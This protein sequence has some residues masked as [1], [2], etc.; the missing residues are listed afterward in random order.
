MG[1]EFLQSSSG[2]TNSPSDN[3][4]FL[5]EPEE[6]SRLGVLALRSHP[7]LVIWC[8]GNE[9]AW[10]GRIP[11]DERHLN[12]KMLKGIVRELDP[13]RPFFP[14]SPSGPR[15]NF[16]LADV[17]KGVHHDIH[18]PWSYLGDGAHYEEFN[19]DDSLF[20]SETGAPSASRWEA[21]HRYAGGYAVWPPKRDNP[22]S[23]HRGSW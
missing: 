23:L 15:F 5:R 20:R 8:S 6:V 10:E 3:P 4:S 17:G 21:I 16:S 13:A 1:Q 2:L 12:I 11:V 14:T 18:R 22:Y 7:S 9:L 19:V